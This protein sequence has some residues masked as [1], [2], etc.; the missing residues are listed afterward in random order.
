MGRAWK[1]G[2]MCARIASM[3]A[4]VSKREILVKVAGLAVVLAAMFGIFHYFGVTDIQNRIEEAGVWAP[5]LFVLAK[6]ATLVLAPLSGG[7]VYLIAG[8]LFGFWKGVLLV[9]IGDVIG[10]T[11]AF[12]LSRFF[13]RTLVERM[14]G[15]GSSMLARAL[16]MAGTTKG[17]ILMRIFFAPIQEVACY[18]A[19]LTRIPFPTFLL[20]HGL[21]GVVPTMLLVGLGSLSAII[22]NPLIMGAAIIAGLA[23][24]PILFFVFRSLVKD[25]HEPSST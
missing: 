13:G 2:E 16:R 9:I 25:T 14:L 5:V 10:G 8:A 3:P 21:I 4:V 7:P 22:E 1:K 24:F 19:G 17:F 6:I 11:I 18:A 23:A 15:N 12:F 20:I